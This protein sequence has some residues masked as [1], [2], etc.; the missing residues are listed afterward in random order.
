M[1]N[2][3]R[4]DFLKKSLLT[5]VGLITLPEILRQS[6]F[7]IGSPNKLIQFAQI[8]CGRE[9]TSDYEG[10]MKHTDLCRMVAVCDLDSRRVDLAKKTVEEFY[11]N[12]GETNVDVKA[13]HDFNEVLARPD[14]DAV[15]VS[16]PDH[17]HAFVAVKAVL[18]GKDVYVQKPLTY[19][20]SEAIALRT[21]VRSRKIILQTG[22]QQRSEKPWNTFRIASEAV[23][24]GRIGKLHSVKIGIGIDKIKGVK[25]LPQTPPSTFDYER[26]LGAAP[27]QPYMEF[28]CHPQDSIDGRPGWI[29]TEDFGLGMITNWGA[30]HMDI[31][32]WAMGLELD[33]PLSVVAKADFM[34]DDVWTVHTTYHAEMMYPGN[35]QVI[36]DNKFTNG[37]QFEGSDGMVFCARGSE[38]V[39]KSDPVSTVDDKKGPLFASNDKIL[40]PRVGSEGKIWMPSADHYRNW[41]ESIISRK[42]PIAPVDQSTRSLE[43]CAVAW[44]GMKLNRKLTWD[45]KKEKFVGDKEANA[46]LS[47]K[48]RKPEYDLTLLMK[49]AG[50]V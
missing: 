46:M 45:A 35:I 2:K 33:G 27:E 13:Y 38:K 23:R 43:A 39:T 9:G 17:Q 6:T 14:I 28:R 7:A 26:W 16:V 44:I 15:I 18:A 12:K 25:P 21:A 29:T 31:A 47:R 49:K 3:T 22:S 19:S 10:T 34:K 5:G 36:L 24:N 1:K 37:I 50:L 4:R 32:H 41:L 40:Y 48:A 20:I 11:R 8:G 30:H 42:D